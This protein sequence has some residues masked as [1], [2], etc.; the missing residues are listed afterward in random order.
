MHSD[1]FASLQDHNG[2]ELLDLDL[3]SE[4]QAR[5]DFDL[6]DFV[7]KFEDEE[8]GPGG[9]IRGQTITNTPILGTLPGEGIAQTRVTLEACGINQPHTH[10]AGTEFFYILSGNVNIGLIEET[11]K[12]RREFHEEIHA[13]QTIVFPRGTP[14][15]LAD[16]V[17]PP[18]QSLLSELMRSTKAAT[19]QTINCSWYVTCV[20][21]TES[22]FCP[23]NLSLHIVHP[24]NRTDLPW[25]QALPSSRRSCGLAHA[26]L[27]LIA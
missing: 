26:L 22:L 10:P 21:V 9:S 2:H 5:M 12:G 23:H 17:L 14:R 24:A 16:C 13:G 6:S 4:Q 25:R 7:F 19:F 3:H 8:T 18:I 1:P 20:E 15:T 11:G 27:T